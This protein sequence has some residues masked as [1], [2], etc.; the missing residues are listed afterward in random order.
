MR[1]NTY[2]KYRQTRFILSILFHNYKSLVDASGKPLPEL[3][4]MAVGKLGENIAVRSVRVLYAPS[5]SSLYSAAHPK[6]GSASVSMGKFV[7]V[8]ALKRPELEGLFPTDKLAAQLC[9]HVIGMRSETLGEPPVEQKS[10][11]KKTKMEENR[12]ELNDFEEVQNCIRDYEIR[13]EITR[14]I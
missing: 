6:E 1:K 8:V 13:Y 4:A 2:Q 7:S 5:N 10:E 12:D 3:V 14:A 9:Q 11:E